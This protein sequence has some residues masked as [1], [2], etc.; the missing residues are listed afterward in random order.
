MH[1]PTTGD[2]SDQAW[3]PRLAD[4]GFGHGVQ[5]LEASRCQSRAQGLT[6]S[7]PTASDHDPHPPPQADPLRRTWEPHER[8]LLRSQPRT[9]RLTNPTRAV[10]S[11]LGLVTSATLSRAASKASPVFSRA[12]SNA[13]PVFSRTIE[14]MSS[15]LGV[16]TSRPSR[17]AGTA[18]TNKTATPRPTLSSIPRT[19]TSMYL[20]CLR[21]ASAINRARRRA[22]ASA[23]HGS[24]AGH[25]SGSLQ[26]PDALRD[27][28]TDTVATHRDAI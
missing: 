19:R 6:C 25:S 26:V 22:P 20:W 5:V 27:N 23:T 4:M 7:P 28:S 10:Q 24:S 13:S 9:G 15:P 3:Y 21:N 11:S 12:V 14:T 2:Q 8:S 17:R 16:S 1:L 18:T